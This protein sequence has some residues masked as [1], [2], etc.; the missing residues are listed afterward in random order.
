MASITIRNLDAGLKASLRLRAARR[1]LSME[2]EARNILRNTLASESGATSGLDFA[3]RISQRCKGLG[4][5]GLPLPQ[6]Q[7][8]RPL[9]GFGQT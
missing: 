1:G 5:D 3:L 4:A 9:P 6:R 8:G 2:Q 7:P